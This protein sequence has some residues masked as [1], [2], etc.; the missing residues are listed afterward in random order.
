MDFVWGNNHPSHEFQS[1]PGLPG[2]F[3][4]Y[5]RDLASYGKLFQSRP[6]FPG[7]FARVS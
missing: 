6:G 3:A 4:D 7:H 2:H 1:R 5:V